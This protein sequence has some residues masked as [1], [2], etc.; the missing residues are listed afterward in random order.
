MTPVT[1]TGRPVDSPSPSHQPSC[2]PPQR[3]KIYS[4]TSTRSSSRV[5]LR[6]APSLFSEAK[7]KTSS[8]L[9]SSEHQQHQVPPH[10]LQHPQ[11]LLLKKNHSSNQLYR[12]SK[13]QVSLARKPLKVKGD[14]KRSKPPSLTQAPLPS[15]TA[16]PPTQMKL[17][18]PTFPKPKSRILK[19]S[20]NAM[21]SIDPENLETVYSLWMVFSKFANV[22][23]NGERLENMSWRLWNRDLLYNPHNDMNSASSSFATALEEQRNMSQNFPAPSSKPLVTRFNS[24]TSVPELN[25]VPKLSSSVESSTSSCTTN[26]TN[27]GSSDKLEKP[28][29]PHPYSTTSLSRRSAAIQ[30]KAGSHKSLSSDRLRELLKLFSSDM[31]QEDFLKPIAVRKSV[32]KQFKNDR[33]EQDSLCTGSPDSPIVS[34]PQ[35]HN[36]KSLLN[37]PLNTTRKTASPHNSQPSQPQQNAIPYQQ[38]MHSKSISPTR[39]YPM[40]R[41]LSQPSSQEKGQWASEPS[42]LLTRS[43]PKRYASPLAVALAT[44]SVSNIKSTTTAP[45]SQVSSHLSM[46]H[47]SQSTTDLAQNVSKATAKLARNNSSLFTN[48]NAPL[49]QPSLFSR[50]NHVSQTS[51]NNFTRT[52]LTKSAPPR[53]YSSDDSDTEDDNDLDGVGSAGHRLTQKDRNSSLTSIVRGFAPSSVS[54]AAVPRP[55]KSTVSFAS[56]AEYLR[57]ST[58]PTNVAS[59]AAIT[60]SAANQ[61]PVVST[62]AFEMT[63]A[64]PDKVPR[65]KMFFIE[66]SSPESENDNSLSSQSDDFPSIIKE[67]ET[68]TSEESDERYQ[69]LFNTKKSAAPLASDVKVPIAEEKEANNDDDDNDDDDDDDDDDDFNDDDSAWDSVDDES[70]SESFDETSFVRNETST[71][72][73]LIRPSL[74]SSLFLNKPEKIMEEQAAMKEKAR[75]NETPNSSEKPSPLAQAKYSN[76]T[77]HLVN[78][79]AGNDENGDGSFG[80]LMSPRTTRRTMLASELSESVRRD[81][82]RERKQVVHLMKP[83][84]SGD[85]FSN[86][87]DPKTSNAAPDDGKDAEENNLFKKVSNFDTTKPQRRRTTSKNSATSSS[88]ESWRDDLEE[89][90]KGDFNYHA[91]GW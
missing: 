3:P 33:Q 78:Y 39:T 56:S 28:T 63:K 7:L 77:T 34:T 62:G 21:T 69:S 18:F 90:I 60:P 67:K 20:P 47:M 11:P 30:P 38:P 22:I 74:L 61:P 84:L 45:V 85:A 79:K 12:K 8:G 13:S 51:T 64:R 15:A 25:Q 23:E 44:A 70:D 89:D 40:V 91:R 66:S 24:V 87:I 86:S 54:I 58:S 46:V 53:N 83:K 42:H 88:Q 72:P 65:N 37:S 5:H 76:S 55:N 14:I 82:L 6:T 16:V 17:E 32:E 80:V 26:S 50:P 43:S 4:R 57:N 36:Q 29:S 2:Q 49:K 59:K 31:S 81:L 1:D 68:H 71:L 75:D 10:P 19:L 35:Q 48:P 73:P 27:K 41:R 52:S 9:P